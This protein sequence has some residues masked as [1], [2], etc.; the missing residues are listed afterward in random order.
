[1]AYP[2]I[3]TFNPDELLF[4]PLRRDGKDKEK[5]VGLY[6]IA[7]HGGVT[8]RFLFMTPVVR[9]PFGLSSYKDSGNY[10]IS[11]SFDNLDS[12]TDTKKWYEVMKHMDSRLLDVA[13]ANSQEWFDQQED[14]ATVE[15]FMVR[16]C[17]R[18]PKVD[19]QR[20]VTYPPLMS[21]KVPEGHDFRGNKRCRVFDEECREVDMHDLT[22]G[23]EV[24]LVIEL[25]PNVYFSQRKAGVSWRVYQ[26]K[27][28]RRPPAMDGQCA[29][30]PTSAPAEGQH[31][32]QWA[33]MG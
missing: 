1:M 8:R 3:T 9:L 21:F 25:V 12:D 31:Q 32:D 4:E 18:E 20:G 15:K 30:Q 5:R 24:R 26:A 10:N 29:F 11:V 6:A 22:K 33:A 23:C 13:T 16:K 19:E 2:S 14:R 7:P 17:T 27:I 28:E